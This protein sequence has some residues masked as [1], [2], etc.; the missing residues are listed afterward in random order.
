[1]PGLKQ[2]LGF[3][4]EFS[5]KG[6]PVIWFHNVSVGETNAA[7][8]LIRTIRKRY[9]THSLVV[10]ATTRTGYEL[11]GK[12][13]KREAD[14]IFYMPFDI[15]FVVKKVMRKIRP[16]LILVMEKEIWFNFFRAAQRYR[17]HLVL[18][19][20]RLSEKSA[21]RYSWVRGT[22]KRVLRCV[23]LALMQTNIDAQRL[24]SLGLRS[25]K[26]KVTGNFKFDQKIDKSEIS[27]TA[28]F[29]ERFGFNDSTPLIVAASTHA[30]EEKWI[31]EAFKKIYLSASPNLPRLVLVPRHPE[32]FDEIAKLIK[33]TGL[34]HARRSSPLGLDDELADVVLLDSIGELRSLYPLADLVFV[35][36]SLVPHGGQ[37]I[38]EPALAGK[39]IVT[40]HSMTNFEAVA[41]EF[42]AR[43]AFVRL[44]ELE[45]DLV[46][47]KLAAKFLELLQDTEQKE[48]LAK[49]AYSVMHDNRGAT[50]RTLKYL[51]PFLRV[52]GN[53]PRG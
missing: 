16:S 30:P 32:R 39:T 10:S 23:D 12:I 35:G 40:G 51:E 13:F 25:G 5:S 15:P 28:Y 31:L 22:F 50:A 11:A 37:S 1:M 38:L 8:P 19:N 52:S 26:V 7:R 47:D 53:T 18:V 6:K 21:K 45:A 3:L 43:D 24:M 9:P 41:E 42:A 27:L 36:G 14:L 46:S 29:K 2:R 17:A 44:P 20:G 4:P 33:G 48:R 34:S 49:N